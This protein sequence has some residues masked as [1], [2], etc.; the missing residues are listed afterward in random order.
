MASTTDLDRT[1]YVGNINEE[2]SEEVL[3]T[4]F[5]PFGDIKHIEIPKEHE[6]GELRGFGFVEF[7]EIEDAEHA[8]D[9]R[10]QSELF[11]KVIKVQRAKKLRGP[12]NKAI[13]ADKE[14][15]IKYIENKNVLDAS[16]VPETNAEEI[17]KEEIITE[18]NNEKINNE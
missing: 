7:E 14:Y 15:Q 9:N 4:V 11:G 12:M 10:H 2:V 16:E 1:V 5:I 18:H 13:W 3:Y 6:T 8:I 17:I